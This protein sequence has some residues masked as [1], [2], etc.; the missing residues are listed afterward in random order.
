MTKRVEK[1]GKKI[2]TVEKIEKKINRGGKRPG[3]GRKKGSPNK[4]SAA[5]IKAV[6][7]SGVTPLAYLLNVMRNPI[8]V[9]V[10]PLVKVEM[11]GQRFEA[12]KAAAPYCHARLAAIEHT[13]K[14]GGPMDMHW[15]V[16]FVKP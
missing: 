12:A 14:D 11:I 5:V 8:P 3:S 7:E 6:E 9:D 15:T 10:E 13:G 4:K 1:K 16:Q 2:N